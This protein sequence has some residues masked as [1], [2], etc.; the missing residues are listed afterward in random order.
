MLGH[1]VS[2]TPALVSIFL[3]CLY[4]MTKKETAILSFLLTVKILKILTP[5]KND[6]IIP[7]LEHYRFTIE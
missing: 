1:S 4:D 2:Y 7:K 6:V 5:Q 3:L